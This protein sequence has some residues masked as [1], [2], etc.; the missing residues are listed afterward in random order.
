METEKENF[1]HLLFSGGVNTELALEI[2]RGNDKLRR[3]IKIELMPI[4]RS[5]GRKRL[6]SLPSFIQDKDL[7][8]QESIKNNTLENW[9][10]CPA[11][12]LSFQS[13]TLSN[14]RLKILPNAIG[15]LK[16]LKRL[17][18]PINE[19]STLPP[20]FIN[21]HH[22]TELSLSFNQLILLP[23]S[24]GQL[25][26]LEALYLN[27]NQLT[28]LPESFGKLTNLKILNISGNQIRTVPKSFKQLRNL[29]TLLI[30]RNSC[31]EAE[32]E[33]LKVMM[34]NCDFKLEG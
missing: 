22:L 11:L 9:L 34:P 26:Q 30:D 4:L 20:S 16:N 33:E 23:E 27:K 5:F 3:S 14:S 12:L 1:Y 2:L 10:H 7:Y 13:L 6:F 31:S 19:L 25:H 29:E 32:L 24:F 8:L 21:L 15:E 18:L 17:R 28:S